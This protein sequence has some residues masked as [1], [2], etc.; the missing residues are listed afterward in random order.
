MAPHVTDEVQHFYRM[1]QHKAVVRA[2]PMIGSQA[3]SGTLARQYLLSSKL[4]QTS[5]V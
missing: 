5:G 3:V 4:L 1:E 2:V